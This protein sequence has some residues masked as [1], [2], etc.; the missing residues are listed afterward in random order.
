MLRSFMPK[1]RS[2]RG[3]PL[4]WR[5]A[6]HSGSWYEDNVHILSQ[7]MDKWLEDTDGHAPIPPGR[8]RAVIAPHAGYRYCGHVMAHAYR[9]M[10][11]NFM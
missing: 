1:T 2:L 6:T 11:P 8:C 4:K 5:T 7:Q 10:N 3:P 9:H